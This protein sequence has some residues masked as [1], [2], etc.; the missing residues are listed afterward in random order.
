MNF[1]AKTGEIKDILE[2]HTSEYMAKLQ[3]RV[4]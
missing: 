3:G 2:Y 4:E 1:V